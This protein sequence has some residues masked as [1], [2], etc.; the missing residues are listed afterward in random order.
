MVFESPQMVEPTDFD[1]NDTDSNTERAEQYLSDDKKEVIEDTDE[2]IFIKNGSKNSGS[3]S[4][5]SKD[6]GLIKFYLRYK[7][8]DWGLIGKSVTQIAL[9]RFPTFLRNVGLT[10]KIF[11]D[12]LLKRWDT[13]ISDDRHTWNG[14]RFWEGV[15]GEASEKGYDV[16]YYNSKDI[17]NTLNFYDGNPNHLSFWM[18]DNYKWG[19]EDE[20]KEWVYLITK[21]RSD[22]EK[23]ILRYKK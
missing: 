6:D 15:M 2:Y 7:E 17:I 9:W 12:I 22:F 8:K 23:H 14:R 19:K 10:S 18:H 5:I 16:G 21:R 1:L 20:Y 4:M 11:F 13:I 3:F